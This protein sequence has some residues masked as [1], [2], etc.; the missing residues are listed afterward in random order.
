MPTAPKTERRKAERPGKNDTPRP[1]A[2]VIPFPTRTAA[3]KA[4]PAGEARG[5]IL[6]FLG[7]RYERLAS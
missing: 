3:R 2:L 4:P 1:G 5:E 7:V 6:L